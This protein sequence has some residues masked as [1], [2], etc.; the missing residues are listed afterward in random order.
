MIFEFDDICSRKVK[1]DINS[2]NYIND[3]EIFIGIDGKI[4]NNLNIEKIKELYLKSGENFINKI[5]GYFSIYI[6]DKQKN[7]LLLIKDLIGL[8][9]IYYYVGNDC[10]CCG[11]DLMKLVNSF[12]IEKTIN[13][14]A[15]SMYFRYHYIN[16]PQ[17]IFK[18]FY[19]LKHGHYV[20]Y[21]DDK[22][23]DNTYWDV[24]NDYNIVSQELEKDVNVIKKNLDEKLNSCV[25][26][27]VTKHDNYGI[28]ISG[29]I[30]STLI[31]ALCTKYSNKK[32]NTFSIGFYDNDFNEAEQSKK[33]AEYLGTNHHELYITEEK[34][35]E[36]LKKI[37]KYYSEPFADSSELPTIILNEFAK[38]FNIDIAITGDG[39][40]QLFCGTT[41][42]DT[43]WRCQ[44]SYKLFNPLHIHINPHYLKNR[45]LTYIFSNTNKDY[46]SQ[47]EVVYEELFLEGLFKDNGQKRFEEKMINSKNWQERRL[48]LD[49]DNYACYRLTNKMGLAANMNNIEIRS[50]FF[51]KDLI[52]FSFKIPH[53]F[54]Y[55][56]KNKKY[57]L[58]QVLYDYVPENLMSNNKK[59]FG[60]PMH[61][62][63]QTYLYKDLTR[64]ASKE[65]IENQN[66][67]NYESIQRL[68]KNIENQD[69][70]HILWD[71]YVF[72]LWYEEY[73]YKAL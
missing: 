19:K 38:E 61:K 35:L 36:T 10:I 8:K 57:I 1:F 44:S 64:L 73:F 30:D 23:Q 71:F 46:Q 72:Q 33:I 37:P 65:F 25:K 28:Y 18:N 22:I 11:N 62:W 40:D 9:P 68:I 50:P 60:I 39:A 66:I 67:F 45:K 26:E 53:K 12:N 70:K 7:I 17:T 41:T 47:C 14:D 2:E 3:E 31:T 55:Y 42:Y 52:E 56:N 32:I 4:D 34:L 63:L 59:G 54:K 49:F 6:L 15:L 24:V 20:V 29:G 69:I 16:P 27:L 58:K 5:N 21:K 51:D 13:T 43:V 48:I